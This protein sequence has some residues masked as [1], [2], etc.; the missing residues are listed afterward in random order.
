MVP[1]NKIKAYPSPTGKDILYHANNGNAAST[2][3]DNLLKKEDLFL[4]NSI[5]PVTISLF[6]YEYTD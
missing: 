2:A 6:S 4:P 3:I 5:I 1:N